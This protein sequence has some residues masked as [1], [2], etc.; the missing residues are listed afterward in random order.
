[1]Y[2]SEWT[3][4]YFQEQSWNEKHSST[5][6]SLFLF[7]SR[8]K[9]YAKR[10]NLQ[11]RLPWPRSSKIWSGRFQTRVL[12]Y[13]KFPIQINLKSSFT[14]GKNMKEVY[15]WGFV[16]RVIN[17]RYFFLSTLYPLITKRENIYVYLFLSLRSQVIVWRWIYGSLLIYNVV[18]KKRG[19]SSDNLAKVHVHHIQ[20]ETRTITILILLIL[21]RPMIGTALKELLIFQ[22]R[23]KRNTELR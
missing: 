23:H 14:K 12:W 18:D 16:S 8:G 11:R 3:G 17:T 19:S 7:I 1:M 13:C 20:Y 2:H 10:K 21:Y 4:T 22:S 5:C 6:V 15:F 9:E